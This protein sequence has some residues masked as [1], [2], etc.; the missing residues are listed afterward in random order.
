MAFVKKK[1]IKEWK[2]ILLRAYNILAESILETTG[3][4]VRV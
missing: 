2:R 1:E 4:P 3:L